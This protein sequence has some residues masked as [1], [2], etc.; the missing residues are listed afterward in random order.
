[1]QT[2]LYCRKLHSVW[3]DYVVRVSNKLE[4]LTSLEENKVNISTEAFVLCYEFDKRALLRNHPSSGGN[5][6]DFCAWKTFPCLRT[7]TQGSDK[8]ILFSLK[9]NCNLLLFANEQ[10]ETFSPGAPKIGTKNKLHKRP[11]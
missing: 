6:R 3:H 10:F 1:M 5:Q 7:F 4:P 8:K 2:N 9:E 11:N